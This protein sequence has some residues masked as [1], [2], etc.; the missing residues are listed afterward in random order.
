MSASLEQRRGELV[1]LEQQLLHAA[2]EL[3]RWPD[4]SGRSAV[5][6]DDVT[7]VEEETGAVEDRLAD[8]ASHIAQE[9]RDALERID[10]GTYGHCAVC[11][12]P[13]PE[14]RLDA[15]PYATLCLKDKR[16]SEHDQRPQSPLP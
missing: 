14:A 6:H 12:Q 1:A 2:A 3:K 16:A 9:I 10:N 7:G 11:G 15:V 8:N 13:I 5:L 4:A